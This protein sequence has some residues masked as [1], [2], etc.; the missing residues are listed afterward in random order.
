MS[1]LTEIFSAGV[2]T[3]VK[4]VSDAV[5]PFV[6]TD[7]DRLKIA[8]EVEAKVMD[9]TDKMVSHADAYESELTKRQQNDMGS[10]SW[11]SKNIRPLLLI[12][13]VIEYSVMMLTDGNITIGDYHFVIK[14][15]YTVMMAQSLSTAFAFYFGGRSVEK[16][17][18]MIGS[19]TV[20]KK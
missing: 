7:A 14:N 11:L 20:G 8:A 6:T 2:G 1:I 12:F 13:L 9:F 17:A 18:S 3:L 4:D 15:E 16:I 5:K 19:V 10:D